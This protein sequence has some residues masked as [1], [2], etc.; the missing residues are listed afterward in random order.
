MK[1]FP[2]FVVLAMACPTGRVALAQPSEVD[3]LIEH[4]VE[5]REARKDDEALEVFA[6][7]FQISHGPRAQAQVALAEQ[8]LGKWVQAESD[9]MAALAAQGDAW[10]TRNIAVLQTALGT[11]REHLGDLELRGGVNGAEVFVNGA[12]MGLLP[13]DRPVRVP[14]GTSVLEVKA[15]GYFPLARQ[16]MITPNGTSR[17]VVELRPLEAGGAPVPAPLPS[18]EPS[19]GRPEGGHPPVSPDHPAPHPSAGRR[20]AEWATLGVAAAS[21]VVGAVGLGL[22]DSKASAYNADAGCPGVGGGPQSP[23]CNSLASASKTWETVSVVGFVGAG[24][25][26][27]ASLVLVLTEP[28]GGTQGAGV[29][30]PAVARKPSVGCGPAFLLGGLCRIDF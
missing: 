11:I 16:V 7:A 26:G 10:I 23:G 17:E 21:L 24:A 29:T 22:H 3:T 15:P 13:L 19:A 14:S 5:L 9:M 18:L 4:G 25:I 27:V 2:L 30:R 12:R 28:S 6:K 1:R 20:A 8:A